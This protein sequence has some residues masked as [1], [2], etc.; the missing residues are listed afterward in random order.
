MRGN[1]F[2]WLIFAQECLGQLREVVHPFPK[3][4][5]L[6]E[7]E[8][9][10]LSL[11][12]S[13]VWRPRMTWAFRESGTRNWWIVNFICL[14]FFTLYSIP[15]LMESLGQCLNSSIIPRDS[16]VRSRLVG[17]GDV[18]CKTRLCPTHYPA[19]ADLLVHPLVV[20]QSDRYQL[21]GEYPKPVIWLTLPLFCA[22]N[23]ADTSCA[24]KE[25]GGAGV[26]TAPTSDWLTTSLQ[27]VVH[28]NTSCTVLS[29]IPLTWLHN[30]A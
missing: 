21:T 23:I 10:R 1:L 27:L 6:D 28:L 5:Q 17:L 16:S 14:S 24:G 29:T 15:S 30:N 13:C 18:G 3:E 7:R 22:T 8:C 20:R 11:M 4:S 26:T 19:P 9:A 25:G 12:T 2:H